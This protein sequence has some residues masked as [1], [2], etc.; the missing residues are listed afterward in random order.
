MKRVSREPNV[1]S[2]SALDL[3]CS[4]MG[5]FMIL[6]FIVLPYYKNQGRDPLLDENRSLIKD[7]ESVTQQSAVQVLRLEALEQTIVDQKNTIS[8]LVR[9]NSD[10]ERQRDLIEKGRED[11]SRSNEQLRLRAESL[12]QQLADHKK[13]M[14]RVEPGG[15]LQQD[16]IF[17]DLVIHNQKLKFENDDL[18]QRLGLLEASHQ[19]LLGRNEVL[20]SEYASIKTQTT[21]IIPQN[22]KLMREVDDLR[23]QV[24]A[25]RPKNL[26]VVFVIDTTSSMSDQI[27]DLK[28]NIDSI[29]V[30]LQRVSRSLKLGIVEYKDH[31][32]KVPVNSFPLSEV[33]SMQKGASAP[34]VLST[35]RLFLSKFEAE[36]TARNVDVPEAVEL[37]LAAAIQNDWSRISSNDEETIQMI[38]IVGDAPAKGQFVEEAFSLAR[39]W[40][41]GNPNRVV[42]TV[43]VGPIGSAIGTQTFFKTLAQEGGGQYSTAHYKLIGNVLDSVLYGF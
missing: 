22:E 9:S 37:G 35:I 20:L 16:S 1:F 11:I 13:R 31:Q 41:D 43:Y 23:K 2:I 38:L 18:Q 28:D 30:V 5:T 33:P 14:T 21:H 10:L 25:L 27:E 6:T 39:N 42:N 40:H 17:D 19:D 32:D 3:F 36:L 12:E 26:E 29:I 24:S 4:A 34:A 15:P 7:L 8:D